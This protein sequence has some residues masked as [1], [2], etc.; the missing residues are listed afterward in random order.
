MTTSVVSNGVPTPITTK[1]NAGT[2][3]MN[4]G[5]KSFFFIAKTPLCGLSRPFR[6][7]KPTIF[8]NFNRCFQ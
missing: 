6:R 2:A 5:N 1:P 3:A 7:V 8:P 4:A